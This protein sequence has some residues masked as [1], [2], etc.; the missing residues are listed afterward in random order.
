MATTQSLVG[1]DETFELTG[2]VQYDVQLSVGFDVPNQ[3]DEVLPVWRSVDD[4]RCVVGQEQIGPVERTLGV[5]MR[6][7]GRSRIGATISLVPGPARRMGL[8]RI[9]VIDGRNGAIYY[10]YL[11]HK[12][13]LSRYVGAIAL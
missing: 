4:E 8:L 12:Y 5:S 13:L 2:P 1:R 6:I 11:R 9:G 3:G 10:N 7:F